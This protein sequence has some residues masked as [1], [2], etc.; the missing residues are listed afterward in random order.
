MPL[1]TPERFTPHGPDDLVPGTGCYQ[2]PP[3]ATVATTTTDHKKNQPKN[4]PENKIIDPR[5]QQKKINRLK[6]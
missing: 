2:S 6:N 5:T 1:V 4:N 3:V